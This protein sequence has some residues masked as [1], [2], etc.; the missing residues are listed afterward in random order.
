M[1]GA[2]V[3]YVMLQLFHLKISQWILGVP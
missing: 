3:L 1:A 2:T